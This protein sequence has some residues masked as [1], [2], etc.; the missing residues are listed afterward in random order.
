MNVGIVLV[1]FNRLNDLKKTLAAYEAQT[2][3]PGFVLVVDNKS[4]DGTDQYLAEWLSENGRFER[5]VLTLPEN[6]GG[7]GGFYSGMKAAL[8]TNCDWVFV[9]DDDAVP[10][11]DMLE[12]LI[13][14]YNEHP[15]EIVSAAA[16]CTS[17]NNQGR[18]EGIHRCRIEKSIMGYWEKYVPESEYKK[19]FFYIDIYSFVGTMI[20][21]SALEQA[22]LARGDFFIY[23]DDYEHAVRVGKVGK[24]ICVPS[25]VMD[26]VDN[27]NYEKKATWRDYY[28]TRNAVIMHRT[29][30]GEY[31][32]MTRA[33]RR[34]LVAFSTLNLE[35]IKVIW[36][37]VI[38]G[39]KQNTG[40]HPVYKP[41]WKPKG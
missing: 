18:C 31:A 38:D 21:K 24:I 6:M 37:G 8:E 25:S 36:T 16:L 30:F 10:H 29:H 35:K 39:Y 34:L 19:E 13:T 14:F 22:G 41:G 3:A 12:K 5:K 32:G 20:R 17:V 26:H 4:T 7:S 15:E 28:A 2:M 1:T 11:P 9:A 33:L 27:L 40:K 23:N